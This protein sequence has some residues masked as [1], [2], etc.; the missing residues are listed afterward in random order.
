MSF[1]KSERS[2]KSGKRDIDSVQFWGKGDIV[3]TGIMSRSA[4]ESA[5]ASHQSSKGAA[6][7][8]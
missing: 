3:G 4:K 2:I 8:G 1:A 5:K 7:L 6:N